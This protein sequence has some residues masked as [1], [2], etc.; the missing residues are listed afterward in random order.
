MDI[1]QALSDV[2]QMYCLTYV[3]VLLDSVLILKQL[4]V[5]KFFPFLIH[6]Q[7]SKDQKALEYIKQ[8]VFTT[9][10]LPIYLH[11]VNFI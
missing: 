5:F 11:R 6:S 2:L 9:S 1:R 4:V 10:C 7:D 8:K 3:S